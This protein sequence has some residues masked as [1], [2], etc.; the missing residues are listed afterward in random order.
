VLR[1]R[2]GPAGAPELAAVW[3]HAEQ[4]DRALAALVTDGLVVEEGGSYRLP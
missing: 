4:R 1:D 2:P 3:Q